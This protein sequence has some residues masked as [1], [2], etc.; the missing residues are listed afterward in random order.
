MEIAE[1]TRLFNQSLLAKWEQLSLKVDDFIGKMVGMLGDH[2]NDVKKTF[3]LMFE[4]KQQVIQTTLSY[5]YFLSLEPDELDA[6]LRPREAELTAQ[7]PGWN[8]LLQEKRTALAKEMRDSLAYELGTRIFD[9]ELSSDEQK[10]LELFFYGGCSMHKDL[11][12]VKG[13]VAAFTDF[14]KENNITPPV[15]LPNKDNDAALR[16]GKATG[17]DAV[18]E[19]ALESSTHGG[20]KATTLAGKVTYAACS[21]S[22]MGEGAVFNRKDPKK[23]QQNMFQFTFE[24]T[25]RFIISFPST[26]NT[27][28]QSHCAATAELTTNQE[29]YIKYLHV[30]HDSKKA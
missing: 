28:Y 25:F 11:N 7:H 29:W 6:L 30:V 14:C 19:R 24:K 13:G 20:V 21:N 3:Q 26:S 17:A 23:G 2:A 8:D 16:L 22:D 1:I 12:A 27:Q 15:L 4:W 9:K 10:E 5:E 18:V